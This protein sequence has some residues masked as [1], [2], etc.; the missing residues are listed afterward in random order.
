[1]GE[2]PTSAEGSSVSLDA[3]KVSMPSFISSPYDNEEH[4]FTFKTYHLTPNH[5]YVQTLLSLGS[6]A[7]RLLLSCPV[8]N[9]LK[10]KTLP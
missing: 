7:H 1:M 9:C 8:G 4:V 5:R 2:F 6:A 10:N 3:A